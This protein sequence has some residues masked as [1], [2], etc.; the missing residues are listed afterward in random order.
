MKEKNSQVYRGI[1]RNKQSVMCVTSSHEG[2]DGIT[3][4]KLIVFLP[5]QRKRI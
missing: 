1:E 4:R 2:V 3:V 5:K